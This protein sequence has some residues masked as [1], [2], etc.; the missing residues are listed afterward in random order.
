[1]KTFDWLDL[2]NRMVAKGWQQRDYPQLTVSLTKEI[3]GKT[4]TI[5]LP[6][7]LCYNRLAKNGRIC[8]WVYK[9]GKD[10]LLSAPYFY[11]A[12]TI[13]NDRKLAQFRAWLI[14]LYDL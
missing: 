5:V 10:D 7:D 6:W 14:N 13:P 9:P 11:Y 8:A 4:Y 12:A 1:M 2:P 3:E